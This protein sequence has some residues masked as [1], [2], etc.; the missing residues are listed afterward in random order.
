MKNRYPY[1]VQMASIKKGD[2]RLQEYVDKGYGP[3]RLGLENYKL[4]RTIKKIV[5]GSSRP[6]KTCDIFPGSKLVGYGWEWTAYKFPYKKEVVKTP[7]GIFGEVNEPGYLE[8]TKYAYQVCRKYLNKFTV[9]STFERRRL[10]NKYINLIFQRMLPSK[11]YQYV[12][13]NNINKKLKNNLIKLGEGM[14][15]VLEDFDWM[16]DMNL[17]KNMFKN[18]WGIWN[19]IIKDN[20]PN[21]FDFT[22]YHDVFRHYPQRT[23]REVRIKGN[24]WKR[25]LKELKKD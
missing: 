10:K 7:A 5:A 3:I 23:K 6:P 18:N 4:W 14:L 2:W 8:N 22:S 15:A 11:Q 24:N 20:E 19:I 21:I 9:K 13:P 16:P 12:E 25:F 1:P 17:H